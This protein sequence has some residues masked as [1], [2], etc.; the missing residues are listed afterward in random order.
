MF[1]FDECYNL[2][3]DGITENYIEDRERDPKELLREDESEDF[4]GEESLDESII[5]YFGS[6]D[7]LDKILE[8]FDEE[9]K[10]HNTRTFT[11]SSED[12]YVAEVGN[13]KSKKAL[14]KSSP[15]L[16]DELKKRAELQLGYE[17]PNEFK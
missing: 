14:I 9:T 12:E 10:L 7:A 13:R 15:V 4:V 8:D 6:K 17:D 3:E 5:H 16:L 11:D 1:N 2:I